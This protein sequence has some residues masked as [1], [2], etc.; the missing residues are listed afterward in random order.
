[1][2][3]LGWYINNISIINKPETT[4]TVVEDVL[5]E[6]ES[7]ETFTFDLRNFNNPTI[8]KANNTF[9]NNIENLPMDAVV[10]IVETGR[11]IKTNPKDGTFTL[12]HPANKEGESWTIRVEA[13]GLKT[14][15]EKVQIKDKEVVIKN[16]VLEPKGEEPIE[17]LEITNISPSEDVVLK[18]GEKVK[19]SFNAPEGGKGYYK[20]MLPF[21]IL[22]T[23][24]GI[25]MEEK[26]PGYYEGTWIAL[27][28]IVIEDLKVELVFVSKEDEIVTIMAN[29]KITIVKSEEPVDDKLPLESLPANAVDRK[30]VV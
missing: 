24:I 6:N 10:T 13:P 25:P 14:I 3:D 21:G 26:T 15:E 4:E 20:V 27:E 7:K 23:E 11:S 5:V 19:V 12:Y 2:S 8:E 1:M 22:A 30:S 29:G 28:G 9:E 17:P 16:F 18:T